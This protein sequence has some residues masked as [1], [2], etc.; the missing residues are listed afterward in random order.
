MAETTYSY[1]AADFAG[2]KLNPAHLAAEI[3]ASAI[4]TALSGISMTGGTTAQG[5]VSNPT[6]VDIV[7]KAAL[8]AGDK[9]VLDGDTAGPAGGLIAASDNGPT[10]SNTQEVTL[11]G[12]H[13]QIGMQAIQVLN[14]PDLSSDYVRS[15][16]ITAAKQV[17]EILDIYIGDDLTGAQGKCYL[18]G[19]EYRCRTPAFEGSSLD[20]S[21]IDR[22]DTLGLFATY[23]LNT[24]KLS[25]LTFNNGVIA[26]VVV[27]DIAIGGTSGA[28]SGVLAKGADYLDIQFHEATF[29]DGENITFER[30]GSPVASLDCDCTTW[31]EGD[32]IVIQESLKDEWIEGLDI[33][34]IQPGGSKEVPEGL[35][36][37]VKVWNNHTTDDLRVKVS[38]TVG[39]L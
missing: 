25:G 13:T 35:Y 28:R 22:N 24:T 26:D 9:T 16:Q 5:V 1:V 38:L 8:S 33:R 4:V 34:E 7:F 10:V 11:E 23:G 21:I 32:F 29:Q 15:W 14:L 18:A 36:F 37:R 30:A 6:G 17:T 2:S 12:G 3:A 39:R 20:F 31:D 19:G 27:G